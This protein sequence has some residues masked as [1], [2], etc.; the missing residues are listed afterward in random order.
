MFRKIRANLSSQISDA[1]NPPQAASQERKKYILG[2]VFWVPAN[3]CS[4]SHSNSGQSPEDPA[5]AFQTSDGAASDHLAPNPTR[6]RIRDG[7]IS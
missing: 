5:G 4:P 6:K 1:R 2:D 3:H 7:Y